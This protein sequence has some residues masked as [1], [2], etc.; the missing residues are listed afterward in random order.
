[1]K[2]S[3]E[4]VHLGKKNV[5]DNGT[6]LMLDVGFDCVKPKVLI[7]KLKCLD[8]IWTYMCLYP[9]FPAFDSTLRFKIKFRSLQVLEV[10]LFHSICFLSHHGNWSWVT[11]EAQIRLYRP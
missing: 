8:L 1:M 6:E 11:S 10:F 3:G 5:A 2:S 9:L 7:M 4:M